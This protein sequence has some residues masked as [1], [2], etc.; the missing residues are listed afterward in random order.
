ML[1]ARVQSGRDST[2][3][4]LSL[5]TDI[6]VSPL[7]IRPAPVYGYGRPCSSSA[8]TTRPTAIEKAASR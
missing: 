2:A 5:A 7:L 1:A 4:N 6:A 3:R 8:L